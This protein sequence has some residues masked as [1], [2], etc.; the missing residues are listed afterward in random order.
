MHA[1]GGL[2]K[3]KVYCN[4]HDGIITTNLRDIRMHEHTVTRHLRL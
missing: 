3:K 2:L 1:E 4:F